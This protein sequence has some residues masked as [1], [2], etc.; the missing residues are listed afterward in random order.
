MFKVPTLNKRKKEKD[1]TKK[2][3]E[4]QLSLNRF[5]LNDISDVKIIV[6]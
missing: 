2:W 3:K 4:F 6:N 5:E 1:D